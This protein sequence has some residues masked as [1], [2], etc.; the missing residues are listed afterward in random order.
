MYNEDVEIVVA[1]N[2]PEPKSAVAK[3]SASIIRAAGHSS[4]GYGYPLL[5]PC[6]NTSF[7]CDDCTERHAKLI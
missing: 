4:R 3:P 7:M 6:N 1:I 5:L 2:A